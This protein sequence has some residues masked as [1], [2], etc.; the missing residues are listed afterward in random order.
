MTDLQ[1]RIQQR[2]KELE[3]ETVANRRHIHE[4]AELSNTEVDTSAFVEGKLREYG[5]EDIHRPTEFSVVAILDTGRE[6][7]KLALRADLDALAVPESEENLAGPIVRESVGDSLKKEETAAITSYFRHISESFLPTYTTIFIALTF[8]NGRVTAPAFILAMLIMI[9]KEILTATGVIQSLPE[10]FSTLPIPAFLVFA[11]IFFLGTIVAG[12]QAMIVLCM[13]MAMGSVAPGHTGLAM[14]VL[15][16][17]MNYIAMQL[18]PTHICL[19]ICAEDFSVSLGDLVKK[20][21]PL[22]LVFTVISFLYYGI[23]YMAGF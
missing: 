7:K 11:L 23:L 12:S 2:I 13:S 18:S 6:G 3:P 4:L 21:V 10:F 19:T 8:T 15:M 5:F 20:T 16:M 17:C 1:T 9:F 14:F 22:V